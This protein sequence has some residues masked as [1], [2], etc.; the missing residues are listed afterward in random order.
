MNADVS[1]HSPLR[2]HRGSPTARHAGFTLIELLVVIAIIAILAAMLLPALAKAKFSGLVTNC[3]S[4]YRQWCVCCTVYA[5]DNKPGAY[6]SFPLDTVSG[7]NPTDVSSAMVPGLTPYG[8]TVPMWFCPVRP[9]EMDEA[10]AWFQ[11]THHR[12]IGTTADLDLYLESKYNGTY[13]LLNHLYWVPRLNGDGDTFPS[14]AAAGSYHET[15]SPNNILM[16]GWAA[17]T[18]DP[19]ASRQP[20]ISDYCLANGNDTNVADIVNTSGHPFNH[21]LNSV[22]VG[23]ADGHVDTHSVRLI[24]WQMT[25][26][27][28]AQSWFY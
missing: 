3:K 23:Y 25:G 26:N 13:A 10:N 9:Q 6:P 8:L 7:E 11:T 1:S 14:P 17:K 4:N 18:S 15:F 24:Q 16:G 27:D 22:N 21:R 2:R 5:N 19:P 12:Q 20:L 28:G